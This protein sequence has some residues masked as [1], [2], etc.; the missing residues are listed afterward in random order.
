MMHLLSKISFACRDCL[1]CARHSC[2]RYI[3]F[4]REIMG[5]AA[6]A[7]RM[8]EMEAYSHTGTHPCACKEFSPPLTAMT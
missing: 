6:T 4:D 1:S 7:S 3:F 2:E 5:D 8:C